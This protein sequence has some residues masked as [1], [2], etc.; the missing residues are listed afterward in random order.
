MKTSCLDSDKK[1]Q[2]KWLTEQSPKYIVLK[3][4]LK[5]FAKFTGKRL[6]RSSRVN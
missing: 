1:S 2:S 3:A 5:N 4:V 6:C